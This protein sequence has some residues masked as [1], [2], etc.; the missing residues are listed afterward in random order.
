MNRRA[1]LKGA[2]AATLACA[3]PRIARGAMGG[4]SS[5]DPFIMPELAGY[6]PGYSNISGRVPMAAL[7]ADT[8]SVIVYISDS[9]MASSINSIIVPTQAKN[10]NFNVYNG[11]VYT[12]ANPMLS[13]GVNSANLASS[14]APTCVADSLI[15]AGTK[16][17]IISLPL[18][19]GGA[20]TANWALF[21]PGNV[22]GRIAAAKRRLDAAGL[23]ASAV[24]ACLGANDT[25]AGTSL[26]SLQASWTA[27]I[28]NIRAACFICMI[29]VPTCSMFAGS[30]GSNAQTA[31]AGIRNG[32]DI[33]DGGNLDSIPSGSRWDGTHLTAASAVTAGG[34]IAAQLT[35]FL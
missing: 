8:T 24:V 25:N 35:P 20:I 7:T 17:R 5:V 28:A 14:A 22:A 2:S 21:T 16:Q 31:Q 27:V 23:T 11:G 10:Q 13:C 18:G 6:Q 1:L 32:S 33:L 4:A 26:A 12:T 15:T 34:I 29:F 19:V 30:T 3:M 9:M